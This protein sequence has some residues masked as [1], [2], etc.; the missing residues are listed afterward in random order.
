MGFEMTQS[1]SKSNGKIEEAPEEVQ[2]EGAIAP[3]A[4]AALAPPLKQAPFPVHIPVSAPI[5]IPSPTKPRAT[6]LNNP[7]FCAAPSSPSLRSDAQ[8]VVGNLKLVGE[9]IKK[10]CKKS[11][12][13]L[14]APLSLS[15]F[16]PP[17]LG[18]LFILVLIPPTAIKDLMNYDKTNV[19]SQECLAK[20]E[21]VTTISF[22]EAVRSEFE[23]IE[24]ERK[25]IEKGR[26]RL[27]KERK[28]LEKE[29]KSLEKERKEYEGEKRAL[30][31]EK[32]RFQREVMQFNEYVQLE[33]K[34]LVVR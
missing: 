20:K 29:R 4:H 13:L 1:E 24:N 23:E 25:G 3:A 31:E 14:R 18:A 8:K 27:E 34:R 6:N 28:N 11:E 2:K 32:A 15:T 17:A 9:C 10:N 30:D 22:S 33:Y 7:A 12:Y 26:K 19:E 5:P 21:D 16:N